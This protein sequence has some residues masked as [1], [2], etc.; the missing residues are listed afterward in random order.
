M[1]ISTH[2]WMLDSHMN[3]KEI[4]ILMHTANLGLHIR[5]VMQI[6]GPLLTIEVGDGLLEIGL[7]ARRL[8][9]ALIHSVE[10]L[11]IVILSTLGL[12]L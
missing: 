11:A 8:M 5:V 10:V 4:A 9:L 12:K 3:E 7:L 6:H 1:V 2:E